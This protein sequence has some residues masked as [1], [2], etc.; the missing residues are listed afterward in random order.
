[1]DHARV[2]PERAPRGVDDDGA[3]L[4]D[5]VLRFER[6]DEELPPLLAELRVPFLVT[7]DSGEMLAHARRHGLVP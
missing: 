4:V 5:R 2:E 1:V 3:L 7:A 6:L